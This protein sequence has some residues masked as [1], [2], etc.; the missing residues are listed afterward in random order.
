VRAAGMDDYMT[1][2]VSTRAARR[3]GAALGRA[4]A[5]ARCV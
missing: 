4:D 3:G 5:L 2:P 1:T